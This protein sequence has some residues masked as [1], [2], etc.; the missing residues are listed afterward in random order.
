[1]EYFNTGSEWIIHD[2]ESEPE[3][4]KDISGYSVYC[5]SWNTDGIKKE[6][7]DAAG[8]DPDDVILYEF[9]KYINVPA[10]KEAI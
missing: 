9:D 7:A 4:V 10:D 1:M 3:T 8:S 2:E 6:I 5:Y